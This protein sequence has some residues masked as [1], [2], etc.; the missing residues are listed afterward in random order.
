M[1]D[2]APDPEEVRPPHARAT[3]IMSIAILQPSPALHG[4]VCV[5][6][7]VHALCID[8]FATHQDFVQAHVQQGSFM[9]SFGHFAAQG[10]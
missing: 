5:C 10:L 8:A 9:I 6:V 1:G 4:R 3:C 7:C 2:G